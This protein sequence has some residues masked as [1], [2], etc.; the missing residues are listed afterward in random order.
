M[1]FILKFK[2]LS[3]NQFGFRP[4]SN[5]ESAAIEIVSALRK[6]LDKKKI[7]SI[8]FMDIKKA[9]DLVDRKI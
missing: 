3:S 2:L 4:K 7:A 6:T 1:K 5:T 8:V 9:F